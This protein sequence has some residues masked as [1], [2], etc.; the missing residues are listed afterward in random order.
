MRLKR[1]SLKEQRLKKPALVRA[2]SSRSSKEAYR[3]FLIAG[4]A[5]F[6]QEYAYLQQ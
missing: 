3:S 1:S 2:L 5:S 6:F 4:D